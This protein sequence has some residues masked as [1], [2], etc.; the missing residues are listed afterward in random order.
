VTPHRQPGPRGPLRHRTPSRLATPPAASA[1]R[2]AAGS[3]PD[4][5]WL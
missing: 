5:R 1:V 3:A 4:R 2:S